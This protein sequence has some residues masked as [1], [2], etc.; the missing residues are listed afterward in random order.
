M[1][2][3]VVTAFSAAGYKEYG[4]RMLESWALHNNGHNLIVYTSGMDQVLKGVE[5]RRQED[6]PGWLGFIERWK[7]TKLVQGKEIIPGKWKPRD[8]QKGYSYKFDAL[9]FFR[10]SLVMNHAATVQANGKMIWLDGDTVIRQTLPDNLFARYLPGDCAF[11]YLGREPKH[12]ETGWL[13]FRLPE[14][15][16]VLHGWAEY[17]LT[18][19][20]IHEHEYHSAYLF[21][22]AREKLPGIKGHNLTPGGEGHVIFKCDVGNYFM[23]NKGARKSKGFSPEALGIRKR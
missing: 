18:D 10:M 5:Q 12:S 23:H 17:Y 7:D 8:I 6:I 22:R 2:N 16:P 4:A 19:S 15:L 9:K 21:D 13:I 14:A 11:S 20:F 1:T 3:I